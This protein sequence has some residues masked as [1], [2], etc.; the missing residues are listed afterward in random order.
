MQEVPAEF[1]NMGA[2]LREA[3]A[4]ALHREKTGNGRYDRYRSQ[5]MIFIP[6]HKQEVGSTFRRFFRALADTI[7]KGEYEI[8]EVQEFLKIEKGRFILYKIILIQENT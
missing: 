4:N 6:K 3:Q 2:T 8:P 7:W 1:L 5:R